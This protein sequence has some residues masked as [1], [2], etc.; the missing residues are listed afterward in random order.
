MGIIELRHNTQQRITVGVL[1]TK[2]NKLTGPLDSVYGA[3]LNW[4]YWHYI[5]KTDGAKVDIV[6]RVWEDIPDCAGCYSLILT[7]EDTDQLGHLVL[8]IYDVNLGRPIFKEFSVV[9]QNNW[10]AKYNNKLL[11]VAREAIIE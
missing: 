11:T 8:Y 6:T 7:A 4:Y 9:S 1:L 5:I 3:K 10:D 2:Q